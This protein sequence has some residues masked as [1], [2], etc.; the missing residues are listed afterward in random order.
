MVLPQVTMRCQQL[1][2][3]NSLTLYVI[4]LKGSGE[5]VWMKVSCLTARFSQLLP[6]STK[7]VAR[8]TLGWNYRP[9][10]LTNHLTKIFEKV[11]KKAMVAH[12]EVNQLFNI[13]QHGF[14]EGKSTISQLLSYYD[15]I[16]SMLEDLS[17]IHI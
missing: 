3:E 4:L 11:L 7:V 17:L 8:V 14:T 15:S 13:T 6:Q 1:S 12:L 2:T 10:S 5:S 16:L 9:V